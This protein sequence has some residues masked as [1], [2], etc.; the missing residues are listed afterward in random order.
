MNL[1]GDLENEVVLAA[2]NV[3]SKSLDGMAI[4]PPELGKPFVDIERVKSQLRDK[5]FDWI[6]TVALIDIKA[7]RYIV[8]D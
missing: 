6:L 5:G 8:L 3:E 4:F 2:R 1:R 7:E